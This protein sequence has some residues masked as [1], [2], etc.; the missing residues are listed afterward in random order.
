MNPGDKTAEEK[1]KTLSEANDVLSDPKKRKVYDQVGFYSDNIDPATAEA[2][3]RGGGSGFGAGGFG[4][5]PGAAGNARGGQR[6]VHF[7]FDNFDLGQ[8][9]AG[10]AAAVSATSSPASS[11]AA[12]AQQAEPA[13]M[14]GTD[15][16]YQVSV[17]FW[18]AIRGGSVKL[19]IQRPGTNGHMVTEPVEFRIK[20]G[21][22]EGQR[23]R[24]AGKGN[25]GMRGA[26]PGDLY[27]VVHIE[28]HPVFRRDGDDIYLTLPVMPW[29]AALGAK[30]DVPT[31]DGRA[32]LR[33]P[34]GNAER[35]EAAHAREG[36]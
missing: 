32:Q 8:T 29:E 22:R 17:P 34:P 5:F 2:Y 12:A 24:L 28:P 30:V 3:A 11:A 14:G 4:G 7:D 25:P 1:F 20:P 33:V 23:I 21:T 9:G 31:I 36:R 27:L 19:N 6:E 15:L 13:T 35:P 26:Q 16:E 10:A 18:E